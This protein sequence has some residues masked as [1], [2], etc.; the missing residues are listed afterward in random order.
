MEDL[1]AAIGEGRDPF[2]SGRQGLL[3]TQL[4]EGADRSAHAN[5]AVNLPL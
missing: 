3:T 5:Q 4:L 1:L 2:V